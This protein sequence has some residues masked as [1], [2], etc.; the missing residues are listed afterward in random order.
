MPC[1]LP[2]PLPPSSLPCLVILVLLRPCRLLSSLLP[3]PP[4]QNCPE[5]P[6]RESFSFLGKVAS[7]V[8]R[9]NIVVHTSDYQKEQHS[10]KGEIMRA[11]LLTA[12]ENA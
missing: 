5:N 7:E 11:N 10:F 9:A 6:V 1:S 8:F 12:P 2:S 3:P 4:V